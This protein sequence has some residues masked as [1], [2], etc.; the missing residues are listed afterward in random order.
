MAMTRLP[1]TA[2]AFYPADKKV[3]LDEVQSF[4]AQA[5]LPKL[6]GKLKAI[7]APHAGYMYSGETAGLAY[8]ALKTMA[9]D[10]TK[11]ILMG[12][13]HS[14]YVGQPVFSEEDS[15]ETPLGTIPI[16]Q[17]IKDIIYSEEAHAAERCL[18]TQLP[19]LQV[20]LTKF[21][22]CPI[23]INEYQYSQAL[24]KKIDSV[25]DDET[26]LVISSDLSHFHALEEAEKLDS[27]T[28]QY[29][30]NLDIESIT[31]KSEA[32]GM[33]AIVT[34]MHLAKKMG[35]SGSLLSYTTSAKITGD[36]SNVVGYGAYAFTQ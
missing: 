18:E 9:P 7:I 2:G 17:P 3:L 34:L 1:I 10:I 15:W 16:Y 31:Q 35:W 14:I 28:I 6:S 24:A 33:A 30:K 12:P 27:M 8:R 36:H 19:F 22:L 20:A 5:S 11:I 32:C 4:L 23:L 13:S 21:S 26:L 29:I 25:L